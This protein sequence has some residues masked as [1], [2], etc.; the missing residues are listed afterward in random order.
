MSMRGREMR[1]REKR[2]YVRK[3]IVKIRREVF[4]K[5]IYHILM[6]LQKKEKEIFL[7]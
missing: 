4:L 3:K 5:K 6:F 1:K 2:K 7:L